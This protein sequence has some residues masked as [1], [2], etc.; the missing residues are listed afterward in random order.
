MLA[1]LRWGYIDYY[2]DLDKSTVA[3][4]QQLYRLAVHETS[5]EE[6]RKRMLNDRQY[7]VYAE[8]VMGMFVKS[9]EPVLEEALTM[10]LARSCMY[11]HYTAFA[12]QKNSPYTAYFDGKIMK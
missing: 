8:V 10:R 11:N 5:V 1:E 3:S 12:L 4:Y 7:A 9:I 6:R 2:M